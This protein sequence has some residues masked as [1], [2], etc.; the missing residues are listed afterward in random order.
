MP[1][2]NSMEIH[3]WRPTTRQHWW[4]PNATNGGTGIRQ[5]S[6]FGTGSDQDSLRI[7]LLERTL[8]SALDLLMLCSS[9]VKKLDLELLWAS[10]GSASWNHILFKW[11]FV[12]SV[13]G[14]IF[15]QLRLQIDF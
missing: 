6:K 13:A 14:T 10:G 8:S 12:K 9:S 7:Y 15:M 2:E 11:T 5:P 3:R 1:L 4:S